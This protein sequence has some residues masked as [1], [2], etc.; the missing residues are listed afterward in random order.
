MLLKKVEHFISVRWKAYFFLASNSQ[1]RTQGIQE[2]CGFKTNK[3]PP[4]I[5]ELD[6]F[7]SNLIGLVRS[8][9]YKSIDNSIQQQIRRHHKNIKRSNKVF[10]LGQTN[11]ISCMVWV[12]TNIAGP[13]GIRAGWGIETNGRF[14]AERPSASAGP[15]SG[16][17]TATLTPLSPMYSTRPSCLV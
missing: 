5:K 14:V 16:G 13:S 9:I 4:R 8:I 12:L 11:Q 10:F 15:P 17:R 2:T 6:N 1:T 7:E 3:Y